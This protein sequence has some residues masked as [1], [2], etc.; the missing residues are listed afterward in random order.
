VQAA[1]ARLRKLLRRLRRS[2][3]QI[4]RQNRALVRARRAAEAASRAKG[5]FLAN[6][7]HEIRTPMNAIIGMTEILLGT[8]L[9]PEQHE[10]L[11]IVQASATALLTLLNDTLDLSKIEA[12]KFDLDP[13]EVDPREVLGDALKAL[14]LKAHQKGLELCGGVDTDVPAVVVADPGR[15]RQVLLNLV[16]N[17]IKFTSA[18]EVVARVEIQESAPEAL[19]LHFA[20]SD[21]GIGISAD[22]QRAIF[23]PFE[24]ADGST[25]RKYGGTGLGLTICRRLVELMDGTLW[26]ESAPGRGSTFHFTARL[27]LPCSPR[28]PEPANPLAHL[29][30]QRA[31]LV[32]DNRTHRCLLEAL[33][34]GWQMKPVA[35]ADPQAALAELERVQAGDEPFALA[36]L[37]ATLPGT[38][39]FALAEKTKRHA[40]LEGPVLVMLSSADWQAD[41]A[42]CRELDTGYVIKPF[43]E[44]DLRKA[45]LGTPAEK[46]GAPQA[47]PDREGI[48]RLRILLVDDNVFNQRVGS[49]KL[50][51]KGQRVRTVGSGREALAALGQEPFD[52]VFMDVQMS[53]MDG[54]EATAAIRAREKVAGGH[55]PIVAMTAAA[56][57]GDRERCLEAGMDGYITK[58]VEDRTLWQVLREFAPAAAALVHAPGLQALEQRAP[59][60]APLLDRATLL[61]QVGGNTQLL[62]E[63]VNLFRTESVPLLM[64][65]LAALHAREC[66]RLEKAAH[67]LKGMLGFFGAR[68]AIEAACRLETIGHEGTLGTAEDAWTALAAEMEALDSALDKLS[69]KADL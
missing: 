33:L 28:L 36:L 68:A 60:P 53:D 1:N 10:H 39:G 48:P 29:Q 65:I 13:V 40:A 59:T 43:K 27:A 31:L 61:E 64:E 26:V 56:M 58:P 14:A 19:C 67:R 25:T 17:A 38:D 9:A 55:I 4:H 50:Q 11:E 37:D 66:H 20:V 52:L 6:V 49:L 21:T 15:L 47:G 8:P 51:Q 23:E 12:G 2:R 7:S 62:Q 57:K 3:D 22:K 45:V 34:T 32:E 42:R 46:G 18:G 54:F 44:A 16:G 5:E 30:D 41:I 24:Q 35:V 69:G 63:L